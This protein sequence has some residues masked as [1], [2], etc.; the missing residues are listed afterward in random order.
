MTLKTMTKFSRRE[1]MPMPILMSMRFC[2]MTVL[3]LSGVS[4]AAGVHVHGQGQLQVALE[5]EALDIL[6]TIPAMDMVGFE[7][8]PSS[9]AQK[10]AVIAAQQRLQDA[11]AV[12]LLPAE[13]GCKLGSVAVDSELLKDSD[14]KG[15][16]DHAHRRD[17]HSHDSQSHHGHRH[18]HEHKHDHHHKAD[19]QQHD[20]HFHADFSASYH[21]QCS[22][23]GALSMLTMV[24][25][26]DFPALSLKAELV[27]DR[28]VR[29]D[30]LT[31]ETPQLALVSGR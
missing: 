24:L 10:K 6:L 1:M 30:T 26:K 29:S 31:A 21:Y 8:P 20:D 22:Q 15:H 11:A 28:G 14:H 2:L 25:L 19:A 9:G 4:H 3:C 23:P 12:V 5:G 16:K 7:H 18:K 13:A 17:S 27:S